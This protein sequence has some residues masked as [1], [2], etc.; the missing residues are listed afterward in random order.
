MEYI[1]KEIKKP[2]RPN[3]ELLELWL[4]RELSIEKEIT[5][6]NVSVDESHVTVQVLPNGNYKVLISEACFKMISHHVQPE[7]HSHKLKNEDVFHYWLDIKTDRFHAK[8]HIEVK[9]ITSE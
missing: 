3:T 4:E 2:K 9:E 1:N 8:E 5:Y 7:P 6:G